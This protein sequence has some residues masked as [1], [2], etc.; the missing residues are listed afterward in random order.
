MSFSV[1]QAVQNI[2]EGVSINPLANPKGSKLSCELCGKPAYIQCKLCRLTYYCDTEHETI[3]FRGIHEKICQLLIPLRTQDAVFG[4]EEERTSRQAIKLTRQ[5]NLLEITKIEAHKK[6]FEGH[7]DLAIPAALQA[8]RFSM[9]VYGHDSIELV[10]SYLLL[11]ESSIGLKQYKQ[12]EDYLSLAKWAILKVDSA[13][14]TIRA[15]LHRNL[16][17]L[18]SSKGHYDEALRELAYDV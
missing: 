3:D 9:E 7:Y 14:E 12:A 4:S 1:G 17:M 15:Q 11:G 2:M 10:P 8:L 18:Y 16:G 5:I 6:L 13:P